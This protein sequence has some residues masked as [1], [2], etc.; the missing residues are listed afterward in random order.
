M[1][2]T[3]LANFGFKILEPSPPFTDLQFLRGIYLKFII[4]IDQLTREPNATHK[5]VVFLKHIFLKHIFLPQ[6]FISTYW[7]NTNM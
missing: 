1:R 6:F 5:T 7:S 3:Q 4:P 2:V